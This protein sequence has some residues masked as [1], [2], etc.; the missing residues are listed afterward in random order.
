[1][2]TII[3]SD[4]STLAS[5]VRPHV[6]RAHFGWN[7]SWLPAATLLMGDL[8]SWPAIF[9][10]FS[11]LR[12]VIIGWHGHIVWPVLI[13]PALVSSIIL[14]LVGAYDRRSLMTSLS[15]TVE[16][17]LA[18]LI[19]LV[20]SI[21]L[22]Y[23]FVTFDDSVKP[24]RVV[25]LL[26][27]AAFGASTLFVRR[28]L[29][30][31]LQAHHSRRNF[32]LIADAKTAS[33]FYRLYRSRRMLQEL[34]IYSTDPRDA[35]LPVLSEAGPSFLANFEEDLAGLDP[36]SDGVIIG[37]PPSQLDPKLAQL[38]AYVHFRHIPVYTLESFHETQ[39]RQVPVESIEAWWAFARESLLARDSIYDHVKRLFDFTVAFTALLL[40]SPLLLI[41]TL[42]VRLDSRGPA[43]FRQIRIGRDGNPFMLFKFRTMRIGSDSG[44]LYTAKNDSRITRLGGFL[45]RTRIDELLQLLNVIRG[46]MS[47]IGP[48]AEWIKCVEKYDGRIPF[49]GYRHLVRPGI[50]GWAQVSYPY[51]ESQ[52]DALEKLKFDLYYIR[53]FSLSL[54]IAI[55][56]KT[57][58]IMLFA[59]GR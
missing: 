30:G 40:L 39:W 52:A 55:V 29:S 10:F 7:I 3:S 58:H 47:I 41:V 24:S 51:G 49:Y 9:L 54:D 16:H 2:E 20:I 45:R 46:D 31:I 36:E 50:T 11:E 42:L 23:S 25:V 4:L 35:G 44:S 21:T 43:I 6:K 19:A 32:Y 8:L 56:L 57:L 37:V 59:K 22:L 17:L 33:S 14:Y 53:N 34:R 12:A 26:D 28:W 1:M 48:R 15:Y 18:L 5:T 38:L 13:F 27:F